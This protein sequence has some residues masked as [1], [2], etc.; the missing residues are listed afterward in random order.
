MPLIQAAI[1]KGVAKSV[2][3]EDSTELTQ[4]ALAQAAAMIESSEK[5]GKDLNPRSTAWFAVRAV[6]SGR[7]S[8]CTNRTDAMSPGALLD[9]RVALDS[10]D[11]PLNGEADG[12][13]PHTETSLHDML[14]SDVE[15][16][17]V[18]AGRRLDWEEVIPAFDGRCLEI[19][20]ATAEGYGTG[21]IASKHGVSAPRIVEIRR[22]AADRVR[23]SLG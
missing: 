15:P 14:T 3:C 17:D 7:R 16:A 19:L 5:K 12:D 2:G 18:A 6:K 21:E 1:G 9:Q 8:T 23:E 22:E 10:M 20:E 11:A 13:D 4:D